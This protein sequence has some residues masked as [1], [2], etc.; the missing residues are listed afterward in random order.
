MN[1]MR[2]SVLDSTPQCPTVGRWSGAIPI[3]TIFTI[4]LLAL[5]CDSGTQEPEAPTPEAAA[6]AGAPA[7]SAVETPAPVARE[8]DIDASRFPTDLPEGVTAAVPEQFPSE[9]PVY[10]G[11]QPAQGKGVDVDGATQSAVQLLTN[12]ALPDVR[13]F[14]SDE[15]VAKG[16][17]LDSEEET[18]ASVIIKA[19]RG[20]C[21]S[22]IL[23]TPSEGGGSD[24]YIL[25]K[26]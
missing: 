26:C 2:S 12:D 23:I 13:K 25:N 3:A 11:A 1:R 16:W 9:M 20:S 18:N 21:T 5:G 22:N 4:V 7:E 19:T 6:D 10:P 17:T 24:I 8:G 14:Y 15:L